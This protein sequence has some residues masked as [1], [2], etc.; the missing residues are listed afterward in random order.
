[1]SV[2]PIVEA[3]YSLAG[4]DEQWLR[5]VVA[6]LSAAYPRYRAG[7]GFFVDFSNPHK[8]RVQAPA[9]TE[10]IIPKS[11]IEEM[12]EVT[13]PEFL[14]HVLSVRAGTLSA[15][16]GTREWLTSP[17][18]KQYYEP[19]GFADA[20]GIVG[21]DARKVGCI[22]GFALA[23]MQRLP[24]AERQ[25]LA[26]VAVHLAVGLRLRR[27]LRGHDPIEGASAVL[28]V[29]GRVLHADQAA[30]SAREDLRRRA[31]AVD[32]A[33]T[34]RVAHDPLEATSLWRG[35]VD[36]RWTVIDHYDHDGRRY[37]VAHENS[38]SLQTP[39]RLSPRE[40][41]VAALAA[42]GSSNKLIGY[43]LGISVSAVGACLASGIRK[44]GL[45]SRAALVQ[46][47]GSIL[48]AEVPRDAE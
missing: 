2:I 3:A 12:Y 30:A 31:L 39:F 4:D 5:D 29:D 24:A 35:L 33:R 26:R 9:F 48:R 7:Y 11:V 41:E 19:L 15:Q 13:P 40:R 42:L 34:R 17:T 37:F 10:S 44:L 18:G 6:R 21:F 32:R 27:A 8:P 16:V 22:A 36:A 20:V 38:V 1:M 28:D 45:P 47:F 25:T 43:E 14:E 23:E 46:S